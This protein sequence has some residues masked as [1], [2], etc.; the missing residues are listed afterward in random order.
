MWKYNNRI[1]TQ[2]RAWTDDNGYQHPKNWAS[3]W[4]ST[5]KTSRGLVWEDNP[6]PVDA[7]FYT[8]RDAD[9]DA[10]EK[11][12]ADELWVD[13]DGNPI[14]DPHTGQQGVN[15]GLKTVHIEEAKRIANALL[16]PTDWMVVR[17]AEDSSK[18]VASKYSTYRAAIRT[19]CAAIEQDIND[20]SSLA[21]F[22]ALWDTPVDSDNEPNGNAPINNWPDVVE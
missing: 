15:K 13:G 1:I 4:D 5:A 2:G 16:A 10:I 7:R 22:M 21:E 14:N 3:V 18:A 8:G 6:T 9:G 19:A 17:A 20:C 11:N 12:L